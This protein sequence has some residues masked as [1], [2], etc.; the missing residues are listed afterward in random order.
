ML[1]PHCGLISDP[2]F[3]HTDLAFPFAVYE[4]KGWGG[5]AREAR[6]Q[7]C[8]AAATYLDMLDAL[9]RFPGLSERPPMYQ[10]A[11]QKRGQVFAITSFG[12]Y[13]H[14]LVGYKRRRSEKE[15]AGTPGVSDSVYVRP[16][17][18][19]MRDIYL[20]PNEMCRYSR[21]CGAVEL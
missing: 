4:A 14:I 17:Y 2:K 5:D 16:D 12:S 7:A 15:Y 1:N 11:A 10:Q 8:S 21:G 3:G 9:S 6:H 13:W 20:G 19:V 18:N